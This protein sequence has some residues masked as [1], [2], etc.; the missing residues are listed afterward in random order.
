MAMDRVIT[1]DL[2]DSKYCARIDAKK[3]RFEVTPPTIKVLYNHF[4]PSSVVDVGCANGLHLKAFKEL[5]LTDLFGIE[6]TEHWAPYIEKYFGTD[7][8]I[9]DLREDWK[10]YGDFNYDL[11][12]SFEVLEHIEE[13]FADQA[14]SNLCNLGNAICCSA[15]PISG[16]FH[17]LNPQPKQ[18]WVEKFEKQEFKYCEDEVE[19]LESIFQSMNCSG[20]FK[21]GLKIFRKDK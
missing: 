4:K 5:G 16:G 7:Y 8:V 3:W 12:I 2:Y 20:W 11:V 19:T 9:W 6:G 10:T 13:E 18:Y 14:V 1:N 15:C 21:T 17:H